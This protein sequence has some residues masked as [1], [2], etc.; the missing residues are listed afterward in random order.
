MVIMGVG[1]EDGKNPL[2]H[3]IKKPGTPWESSEPEG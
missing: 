2:V 3:G 1:N